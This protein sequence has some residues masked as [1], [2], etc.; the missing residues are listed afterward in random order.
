M[1]IKNVIDAYY[2]HANN[3]DWDAWCDLF[4]DD[5]VLDEQLAGRVETLSKL[6]ELM[7]GMSSNY[8][9]FKNKPKQILIDENKAAVISHI[10][11]RATKHPD[12]PIEANVM[13]YFEIANGKIKYM[14]NYHDSKPFKPFLDQ[15]AGK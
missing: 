10:S 14:S 15:L 5:I 13:N 7:K 3:G 8:S 4:D 6:R 9:L 12:D 1:T 11:A 2:T